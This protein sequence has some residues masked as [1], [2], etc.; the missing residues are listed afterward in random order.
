MDQSPAVRFRR[1]AGDIRGEIKLDRGRYYTVCHDESGFDAGTLAN[2]LN[3]YCD[4]Q[5]VGF[6]LTLDHASSPSPH[7]TASTRFAISGCAA[8]ALC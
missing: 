1:F 7:Y 6:A 8:M 4:P 2:E 3:S 5:K